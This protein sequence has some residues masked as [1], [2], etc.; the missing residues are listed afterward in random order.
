[1]LSIQAWSREWSPSS[2]YALSTPPWPAQPAAPRVSIHTASVTVY[3]TPIELTDLL[4]SKYL[5]ILPRMAGIVVR[6]PTVGYGVA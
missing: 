4:F 6:A 2:A 5:Y 1:M 3:D